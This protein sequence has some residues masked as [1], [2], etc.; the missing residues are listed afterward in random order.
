MQGV[1]MIERDVLVHAIC[2]L[3]MGGAVVDWVGCMHACIPDAR[4]NRNEQ[5][6]LVATSP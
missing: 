6:L 5:E 4:H 3:A 2:L 1:V